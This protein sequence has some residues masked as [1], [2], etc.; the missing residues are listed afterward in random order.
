[1]L[2]V[3]LVNLDD[4]LKEWLSCPVTCTVVSRSS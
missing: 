1:V 4:K 3:D 2:S